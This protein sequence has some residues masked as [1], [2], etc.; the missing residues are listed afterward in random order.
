MIDFKQIEKLDIK[1]PV[2]CN[3]RTYYVFDA[4]NKLIAEVF[5]Q[6]V[7]EFIAATLNAFHNDPIRF[8]ELIE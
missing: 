5:D 2:S 1:W 8:G 7:G 4:N 6:N 3:I